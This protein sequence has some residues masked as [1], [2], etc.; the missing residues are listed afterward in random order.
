MYV[1]MYAKKK[2]QD[3]RHGSLMSELRCT[4]YY[5]SWGPVSLGYIVED[6]VLTICRA[7]ERRGRMYGEPMRVYGH[8]KRGVEEIRAP[9]IMNEFLLLGSAM[10]PV[11][12]FF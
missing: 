7:R 5:C 11:Q 3:L 6:E 10:V 12:H 2:K 1:C 9:S 4:T 8:E